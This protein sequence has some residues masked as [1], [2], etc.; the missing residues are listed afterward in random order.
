MRRIPEPELMQSIEQAY[1][2][3]CADFSESNNLFIDNLFSLTS[4]NDKTKILDIGCGDGEIPIKIYKKRVCDITAVDG[5]E[6]MLEHFH[7][8]L[9]INKISS[10]KIIKTIINDRLFINDK[11]DIVM[12]NSLIHHIDDIDS[13]W[14]NLIRLIK[15]DGIIL[16]MDLKRPNDEIHLNKLLQR[17]GG[18]NNT[19][20]RD[21]E[22]SL[23]ASYTI[24]EVKTQLTKIDN[25]S[26][27]IKSVS[28]RHFFVTIEL[29][30]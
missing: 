22:N 13:F 11:F 10:I 7:R 1:A 18:D 16:C 15:D 4:I 24:E 26:F 6:A 29:K 28:D 14:K 17:Y 20:K 5:S 19:L 30:K 12:N 21:F 25:I 27:S 8:K 9:D 2:Y 23:R 3:S